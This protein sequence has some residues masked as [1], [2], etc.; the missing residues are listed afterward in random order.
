MK[1]KIYQVEVMEDGTTYWT[2]NGKRHREDGPAG[3]WNDGT[4]VYYLND[5]IHREDGPAVKYLN[6]KVEY[7]LDGKRYTKGGFYKEIAKRQQ[8]SL[9]CENKEVMIDGIKYKLIK[10]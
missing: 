2:V 9:A 1:S 6:G 5:Q 4:E 8:K 7:W 10:V 3:K